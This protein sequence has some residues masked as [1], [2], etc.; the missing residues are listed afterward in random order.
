MRNAVGFTDQQM[1]LLEQAAAALP[2]AYRGK[3]LQVVASHLAPEPSNSAVERA[4]A[5]ALYKLIRPLL[6]RSL[7]QHSLE[8]DHHAQQQL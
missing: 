7:Q 6:P 4:I 3:F 5:L 8:P 1:Q 2:E